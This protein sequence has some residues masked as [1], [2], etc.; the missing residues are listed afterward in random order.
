MVFFYGINLHEWSIP[1]T[2]ISEFTI[3]NME[4]SPMAT[5]TPIAIDFI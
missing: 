2:P 5:N 3:N 4:H 1:R